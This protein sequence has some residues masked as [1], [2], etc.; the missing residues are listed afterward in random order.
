MHTQRRES[1]SKNTRTWGLKKLINNTMLKLLVALSS[2][3]VPAWVSV[4][5]SFISVRHASFAVQ[6]SL[7]IIVRMVRAELGTETLK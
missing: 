7:I 5:F 2:S 1:A 3:I 4:L 6:C